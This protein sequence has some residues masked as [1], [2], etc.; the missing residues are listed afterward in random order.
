MP[1]TQG[2]TSDNADDLCWLTCGRVWTTR[3]CLYQD[4]TSYWRSEQGANSTRSHLVTWAVHSR[5]PRR[6]R[7]WS[8]SSM[9]TSMSMWTV[10][11]GNH[12]G[13]PWSDSRSQGC[14]H[15]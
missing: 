2:R 1:R 7:S 4:V 6:S 5:E 13:T 8:P 9:S 15:F 11:A 3:G 10:R 14:C 12:P